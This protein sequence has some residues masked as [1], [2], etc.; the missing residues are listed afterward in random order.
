MKFTK[1]VWLGVALLLCCLLLVSIAASTRNQVAAAPIQ[2]NVTNN[3]AV[4]PPSSS[5]GIPAIHPSLAA[6]SPTS[7]RF[8]TADVQAYLH[9]HPFAGGKVVAAAGT[10]AQVASIQFITSAQASTFMQGEK[11]GLPDT[12]TVCYVKIQGPFTLAVPTPPNAKQLPTASYIV[13]IF[14]GQTGNLLTWWA[15]SA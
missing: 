5:P 11:T 4:A 8:T 6:V 14:D 9:S 2:A 3:T 15:P 10:T 12:A 1:P 13:E 7:A